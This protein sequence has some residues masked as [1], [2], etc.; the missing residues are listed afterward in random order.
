MPMWYSPL[1]PECPKVRSFM[2]SLWNDPMSKAI[3]APMDEI[4]E[5]FEKMHRKVC[6]RCQVFGAAN[7]EVQ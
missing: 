6:G 4:F 2:E 5:N 3:G 7:I 1:D